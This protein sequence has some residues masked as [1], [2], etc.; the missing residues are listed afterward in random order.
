MTTKEFNDINLKHGSF[1]TIEEIEKVCKGGGIEKIDP[2]AFDMLCRIRK[3][4]NF[5][6]IINSAYRSP[7]HEISKGRRKDG[8]H[9]EGKAFDIQALNGRQAHAIVRAAMVEGV[10]RIGIAK[11]YVHIDTSKKLPENVI[12][13]Y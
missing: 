9:T 12:W 1:F 8:S 6:F 10:N 11:T 4:A 3:R 13:T 5:P 7:T 2:E